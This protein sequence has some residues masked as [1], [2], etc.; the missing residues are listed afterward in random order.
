MRILFDARGIQPR[1]DGLSHYVRHILMNLLR[2]DAINEYLILMGP[3]LH[4][5]LEREGWLS[6]PN[7]QAVITSIPFMGIAQQIQLP[8]LARR[9]PH[10]S[11]YHYPHFDMPYAVHPRS[12]V[13][14]YDVNH[15]SFD[16]YFHSH[17]RLKRLYS[18]W[19]TRFS[20]AR[21]RH[22]ITIS[23]A[24]NS[25]LLKRFPSL[26]ARKISVIY[27]ALHE[28]FQTRPGEAAV[29]AFREKF[30][31]GND[32]FVL[33][34]GTDRPHKN[35][36]RLL[37][38]YARLRRQS[39]VAHKLL[40]VGSSTDDGTLEHRI[41]AHELKDSAVRLGY[42]SEEELPLAYCVADAFMFCSLS[43]GFGMP[44]LEAMA[45]GLPIVTSNIGAMMEV[46]ADSALLVDPFS[47]HAIADGLHRLL[48]SEPL[49]RECATRGLE[50]VKAF[51]WE[52]A[53]RK[54]LEIY[55]AVAAGEGVV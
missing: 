1:C 33:Y 38:A 10:A 5:E 9:L 48:S 35:L 12:I 23:N 6:R 52:A 37:E 20:A 25:E 30:R 55:T 21:S 8:R 18:I 39:G 13:T 27:P 41:R 40:L 47:S 17:R 3:R 15:I 26:D 36:E 49:R 46:A 43:E 31:L 24:T 51:A 22:V 44:L 14:I 54:T 2:L 29:R 50:R 45:F 19:A 4:G 11:L 34:V 28:R 7:V 53:A 16:G 32:R 42:L